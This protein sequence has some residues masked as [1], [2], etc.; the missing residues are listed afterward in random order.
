MALYGRELRK[1]V[2]EVPRIVDTAL[3]ERHHSEKRKA[4]QQ[5]LKAISAMS[6]SPR[7]SRG[8]L[9]GKAY[10]KSEVVRIHRDPTKHMKYI[11]KWRNTYEEKE[12]IAEVKE[13]DKY[14]VRSQRVTREIASRL[15]PCLYVS[16]C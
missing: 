5:A 3:D 12:D 9:K 15:A 7:K 6:T 13:Q 2:L 1:G 4:A 14:M 8:P 10:K 11:S 16:H